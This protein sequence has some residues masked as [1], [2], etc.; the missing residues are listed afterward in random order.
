[1][2]EGASNVQRCVQVAYASDGIESSW[3]AA[4]PGGMRIIVIKEPPRVAWSQKA[5]KA[6]PASF[7][8]AAATFL[9]C[10]HVAGRQLSS[11]SDR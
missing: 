10:H 2:L 8:D 11:P 6:F 3:S 1:M 7:R 4:L 5:H 9:M